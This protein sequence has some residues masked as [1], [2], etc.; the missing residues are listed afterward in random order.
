MVRVH[1]DAA[2]PG[3]L[4]GVDE[5]RL[6]DRGQDALRRPGVHHRVAAAAL[7]ILAERHLGLAARVVGPRETGK[8]IVNVH[9]T[10]VSWPRRLEAPRS[11]RR[12]RLRSKLAIECS[13]Q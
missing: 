11:G 7:E 6:T 4:G 2:G 10:P 12:L 9:T 8:Q 5:L 1:E 3:I 13:K